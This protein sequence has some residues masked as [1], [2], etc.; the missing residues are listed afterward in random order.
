MDTSVGSFVYPPKV[1]QAWNEVKSCLLS[2]CDT[3]CGWTKGSGPIRRETWWWNDEVEECISKKRKLW[4]EWQKGGSKEPYLLA[5][6]KAKQAVYLARKAAQDAK[7][8]DLSLND[9]KNQLFK[10]AR[11]MKGENQD[12]VGDKCVRDDNSK[13][14]IDD[15]AKLAAWKTHYERLLNVEFDWDSDQ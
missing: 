9:Q 1:D 2:A 12:I 6:R 5:K 3:V 7:F 11:K 4:K 10:Q 13:L 15:Q 14:A 8:G